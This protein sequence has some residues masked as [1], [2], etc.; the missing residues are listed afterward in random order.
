MN[1]GWVTKTTQIQRGD[2]RTEQKWRKLGSESL[3]QRPRLEA[4]GQLPKKVSRQWCHLVN[5]QKR[6][7]CSRENNHGINR[8]W[9]PEV[10]QD[11][12]ALETCSMCRWPDTRVAEDIQWAAGEQWLTLGQD[13][14]QE[15]QSHRNERRKVSRSSYQQ[16]L[17]RHRTDRE[18]FSQRKKASWTKAANHKA[19]ATRRRRRISKISSTQQWLNLSPRVVWLIT[20]LDDNKLDDFTSPPQS[21]FFWQVSMRMA[22]RIIKTR[23]TVISKRKRRHAFSNCRIPMLL[24]VTD[25]F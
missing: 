24:A 1:D 20:T 3:R 2:C 8:N 6:H 18:K 22:A 4:M 25:G 19:Q 13:D 15:E 7:P 21:W 14:N 23:K 16:H 9:K 5:G 12:S 11:N 10:A 17:M